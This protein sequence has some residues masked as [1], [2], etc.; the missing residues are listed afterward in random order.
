[1]QFSCPIL[2]SH[3]HYLSSW[4][5]GVC[6][7]LSI[8]CTYVT[9]WSSFTGVCLL[10]SIHCTFV[11]LW[12]S[13]TRVCLLLSIYCTCVSVIKFSN[14]I[15]CR[16]QHYPTSWIT[17]VCLVLSIHCTCVT[18]WSSFTGVHLVL[19]TCCTCDSV[20]QFQSSY[21]VQAQLMNICSILLIVLVLL[22]VIFHVLA[23]MLFV[24]MLLGCLLFED[25]LTNHYTQF[26]KWWATNNVK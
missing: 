21:S 19:S 9:L 10:L 5:T 18:L 25:I 12:S 11:T 17:G 1:M 16:D 13:F 2:C 22:C 23:T 6:L 7:V 24:P 8:H 26:C 14:S 4:M 3:Q 20:I 15:L